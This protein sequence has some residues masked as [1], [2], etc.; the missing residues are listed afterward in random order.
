[1]E[2][3]FECACRNQGTLLHPSIPLDPLHW[4]CIPGT[5]S[6][7]A[8]S[9]RGWSGSCELKNE[10]TYHFLKWKR[11]RCLCPFLDNKNGHI[12]SFTYLC[13]CVCV[14]VYHLYSAKC[15]NPFGSLCELGTFVWDGGQGSW[16]NHCSMLLLLLLLLSHCSCVRLCATT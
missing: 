9:F 5:S 10:L 3:G 6:F 8:G 7:L 2:P 16:S 15:Y 4:G 14:C 1:M 11:R 12:K 13:V